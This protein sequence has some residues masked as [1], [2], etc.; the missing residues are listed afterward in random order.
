MGPCGGAARKRGEPALLGLFL[1]S[2]WRVFA[3]AL[4]PALAPHRPPLSLITFTP[5]FS[6]P[7]LL[8]PC[9]SRI[10]LFFTPASHSRSSSPDLPPPL[11]RFSQAATSLKIE[12]A[13]KQQERDEPPPSMPSANDMKNPAKMQEYMLQM[14]PKIIN[15]QN[16]G[17]WG[18]C[19]ARR[20]GG[21]EMSVWSSTVDAGRVCGARVDGGIDRRIL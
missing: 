14:G 19:G 7:A 5:L 17:V 9:S 1:R 15:D 11:S 3:A 2:D 6:H 8:A 21:H 13:M 20:A 12:E 18:A 16:A 10:P 4:L